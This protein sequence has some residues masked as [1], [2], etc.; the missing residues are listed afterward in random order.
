MWPEIL[1]QP[2]NPEQ[3]EQVSLPST[4]GEF[5]AMVASRLIST[6]E[7]HELLNRP[8]INSVEL[9]QGE[10]ER[11]FWEHYASFIP[12]KFK[13]MKLFIRL[14]NGL[15][16]TCIIPD[17]DINTMADYDLEHFL[18]RKRL[19]NLEERN[20]TKDH[21]NPASQNP[22]GK[23]ALFRELNFL[24]PVSLKEAGFEIVRKETED[25]I[26]SYVVNSLARAIHSQYLRTVRGQQNNTGHNTAPAY[27]VDYSALPEDIAGSNYDNA[28]HIPTKLLAIGYRIRP[29]KK[30]YKAL[31]LHLDDEEV[32]TMA[33]IEHIRWSWDKRLNGWIY[34]PVRDELRRMHPALVPYEELPG[35]EKDKDRELVKLIP[36][37]LTDIDYE[38]YPI[39]PRNIRHLSYALKPPSIIHKI[40]NETRELNSQIRSMVTLS[41]ETEE[42]VKVRNMKIE[43]AI[44]EIEQSYNYAQRIQENFLPADLL[45]RE[46]F[47]DHFIL[48]K[49]KD[50]VSGD[51]YFFSRT[52]N[53]IVFAVADC[54]G[55]GIPGALL[56]TIGYGIL[57][58]AVNEKKLTDPSCILYHLYSKIHRF[59]RNDSPPGGLLDDLDIILCVLDTD[60][61]TLKYAGV[62]NSLYHITGGELR[63]Y[64]AQNAA[65]ECNVAGECLFFADSISLEAGDSIYLFTDGY[66]DQFGGKYHRKFLSGRL[67]SLLTGIRHLNM[68]EQGD[69]LYEE[70]EIWKD[71]NLED[72]T[73]DVLALG[74][75]F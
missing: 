16:R 37:L 46:L 13:R 18:R 6:A 1:Y 39:D 20:G 51:F 75:R 52:G 27:P 70:F 50:I 14:F 57:D 4:S 67:K 17:Q 33:R 74:I 34:G 26:S 59:L 69:R 40:L 65:D 64:R 24:I 25:L 61:G 68:S 22:A 54:T 49:P 10:S 35:E 73:D 66:V 55:H 56:S 63:E 72:Q 43:Q 60:T 30:G 21:A 47:P 19:H 11:D 36:S 38:A 45:I 29:V 58:Q 48:Y 32:E 28:S 42:M 15:C 8:G 62:K 9:Y 7:R 71:E 12:V 5:N 2:S 3:D 53:E 31:T 41:P 44:N 23:T